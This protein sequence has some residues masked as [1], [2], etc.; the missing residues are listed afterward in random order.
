MTGQRGGGSVDSE[1]S[2]MLGK[3]STGKKQFAGV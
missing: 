2:K 3:G 1:R